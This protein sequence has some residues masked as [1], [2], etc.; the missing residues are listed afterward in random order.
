MRDTNNIDKLFTG[1]KIAYFSMEIGVKPEFHTYS[2]GLGIL[3]GDTVRS[4][5][6]LN[7]P[8]VAVT[9][10]SKKGY[11][12]QEINQDGLQIEHPDDWDPS[13]SMQL[14]PHE[15]EVEIEGTPV[16]IK[17]WLYVV[18]SPY[19]SPVPVF[20]LDTDVEGNSQENRELTHYLYGGQKDYRLKQEIILGIGGLRMLKAAGVDILKYH[21]N[22]GHASFLLLELLNQYN[23]DSQKVKNKCIFTTHTPIEAGHDKF[24]YEMAEKVL[25]SFIDIE[26]T[27]KYAGEE[28]LNMTL[29]ALNLC[30]FVNGVA[31]EHRKTTKKMF[32][33]YTIRSITNGI[34]PY[35]WTHKSFQKMYDNYFPGWALEPGLLARIE[36]IPHEQIWEARLKSKQELITYVNKTFNKNLSPKVL[37]IGFARRATTYKRHTLMFTDLARFKSIAKQHP[38]QIIFA[39]KAHPNDNPGKQMIQE[40]FSYIKQLENDIQIVYLEN[41]DMNIAKKLV[42]GVDIWLNTP[43]K[44]MEASGTSGM[45]AAFNGVL[46]FSVLDGWWIE[47]CIESVT[48]WAIGPSTSEERNLDPKEIYQREK[49][50][51]YGKLEYSILPIY[52]KQRDTWIRMIKSSIGQTAPFFN[53]HR[54]MRRY[55]T[56]AYFL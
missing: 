45:K 23:F 9:L 27:K 26:K 37:T 20:F 16:K 32:P 39:G 12:R 25:P 1:K 11:F 36:I 28:N 24:E 30:N 18:E 35:T 3:A 4:S 10:I 8:F 33:G 14:L 47:G 19:G 53:T 21:L 7:I 55:I 34:H 15:V 52:Y 43:K 51:L 42:S 48:G 38:L 17:S 22:E 6:D 44:P 40:V 54:M 49:H 56:K 41:Y 5:S 13:Q 2:G 50:D 46:N 31:K 29:L